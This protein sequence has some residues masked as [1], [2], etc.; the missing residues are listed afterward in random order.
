[1]LFRAHQT[2]DADCGDYVN[3]S[4][5]RINKVIKIK[6]KRISPDKEDVDC[7][8][9]QKSCRNSN[10]NYLVLTIRE[11]FWQFIIHHGPWT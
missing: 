1:V 3:D 10:G 7:Y 2:P 9:N 8:I 5:G 6:N 4:Q 11:D